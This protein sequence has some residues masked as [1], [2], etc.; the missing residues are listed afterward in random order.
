MDISAVIFS[1]ILAVAALASGLPKVQLQGMTWNFLRD[2]G[3]S[4]RKARS[5]GAAELLCVVGLMAG[6]FWRPVGIAA[7][8]VLIVLFAGALWFH[9]VHGD[10]GNPDR[11]KQALIPLGLVALSVVT[12][13]VLI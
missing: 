3:M 7:S 11:R 12:L 13:I 4:P 5:I 9:F 2:R 6:L 1:V 10:F 8:V